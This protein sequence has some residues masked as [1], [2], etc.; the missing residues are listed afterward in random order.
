MSFC[1]VN[2]IKLYLKTDLYIILKEYLNVSKT[3]AFVSMM[4]FVDC[5]SGCC[6]F[7]L[8]VRMMCLENIRPV[9]FILCDRVT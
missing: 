9:K 4:L 1:N 2:S 5:G 8:L 6:C 3:A 7:Q